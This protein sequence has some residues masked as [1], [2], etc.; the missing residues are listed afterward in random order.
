MM[1]CTTLA[2]LSLTAKLESKEQKSFQNVFPATLMRKEHYALIYSSRKSDFFKTRFL[3]RTRRIKLFRSNDH[4]NFG[5]IANASRLYNR[6]Y[7]FSF[8]ITFLCFTVYCCES[9]S[10]LTCL[11][12]GATCWVVGN[13]FHCDF[14]YHNSVCC[15]SVWGVYDSWMF[16]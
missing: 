10:E 16:I 11:Y 9:W 1:T 6:Q 13:T 2:W 8:L 14:P 7:I 12:S 5:D 3:P 4:L 15:E